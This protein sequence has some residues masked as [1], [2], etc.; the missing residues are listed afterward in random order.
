LRRI[1]NISADDKLDVLISLL[2]ASVYTYIRECASYQEAIDCLE[3]IYVKPVN[4]VHARHKLNTC[5]Q[6][7]EE[8]IEEFFQRLKMFSADCN[9]AAITAAPN[10]D[11]AI[12][13]DFVAGLRSGYIRQCLL[14]D[15]VRELQAALDKART[16]DE[17]QKNCEEYRLSTQSNSVHSVGSAGVCNPGKENSVRTECLSMKTKCYFCGNKRH[18]RFNCP[19]RERVCYKRKTKKGHLSSVCLSKSKD[20]A[21]TAT[22]TSQQ[23]SLSASS[24]VNSDDNK[25]NAFAL[26]NGVLAN[27]LIDTGAKRNHID[28]AFVN[29]TNL[30]VD[31]ST[32]EEI[33]LAV[34]SSTVRTR[35]SCNV[36]IDLRDRSYDK[37]NILV[38]DNLMWDVILGREFL[39]EHQSVIFELA[40]PSVP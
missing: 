36:Q 4:E 6:K 14:E 33:W 3:N 7:S 19:A 21:P 27:C 11:A 34:K 10:R 5:R 8:K 9:F 22:L 17:A 31:D 18:P 28:K 25:V 15:N 24:P 29:R 26:V 37:V 2:D 40:V 12:R 32:K 20:M 38:M 13:D 35:G 23:P 30:P 16:L 39:K 1:D